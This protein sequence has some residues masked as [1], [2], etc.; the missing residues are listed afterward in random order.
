M[1]GNIISGAPLGR[2]SFPPIA[3][4]IFLFASGSLE[5]MCQWPIVRPSSLNGAGCAA[6]LPM[7]SAD[8]SA[9]IAAIALV[10]MD[11]SLC[12]D[13]FLSTG[14]AKG[15][16]SNLRECA[17]ARARAQRRSRHGKEW[18]RQWE[19][20]PT[21]APTGIGDHVQRRMQRREGI[22]GG[23]A[24]A[25]RHLPTGVEERARRND[26]PRPRAFR[27]DDA[28]GPR[29]AAFFVRRDRGRRWRRSLLDGE[30][31][32]ERGGGFV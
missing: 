21:H 20:V 3:R 11:T 12:P 8:A 22:N 9:T 15:N 10:F 7:A 29:N 18:A 24:L 31:L 27:G 4:K 26:H 19:I 14:R 25:R 30:A 2:K 1:P 28:L 13:L 32:V 6:A 17:K 5:M 16:A 23:L